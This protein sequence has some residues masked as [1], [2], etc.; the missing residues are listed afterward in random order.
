MPP[1]RC[2]LLGGVLVV[3]STTTGMLSSSNS[4]VQQ[5]GLPVKGGPDFFTSSGLRKVNRVRIVFVG[6]LFYSKIE[7]LLYNKSL[8][9]EEHKELI[10]EISN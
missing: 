6:W 9:E 8:S 10:N 1:G 2:K 3:I 5:K 4:I 7:L